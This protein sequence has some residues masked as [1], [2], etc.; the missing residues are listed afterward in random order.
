MPFD[1][2]GI[3]TFIMILIRVSSFL[4]TAPFF[5]MPL[6]PGRVRLGLAL[7]LAV[8]LFPSV[9]PVAPDVP[10]G[11]WG[12]AM[13]ALGEAGVGLGMGLVATFVFSAVTVAGQ[14][15]D[16]QI[17]FAMAALVDPASNVNT[18]VLAQ[19][20]FFLAMLLYLDF[21]GHLLLIAALAKSYQLVPLSPS[22]FP[23]PAAGS[24]VRTFAQLFVLA[25]QIAMPLLA[26][27]LVIELVLGFLGRTAPQTNVFMLSFPIN[28]AAGLLTLAIVLPMLA[29]FLNHLFDLLNGR[30]L[31]FL[32]GWA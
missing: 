20:L 7:A 26:V 15:M 14:Y 22:G 29:G 31:D 1:T 5:S 2:A 11:V 30:I 27:L 18:T 6:I 19:Y 28:V 4:M 23:A 9:A 13:T 32:R 21:D 10:G 12:Y 25:V 17:G 16:L 8:A 3:I 24:V